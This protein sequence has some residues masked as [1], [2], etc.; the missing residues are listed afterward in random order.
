[1][2]FPN[3]GKQISDYVKET[4]LNSYQDDDFSR[5]MPGNKDF[6]SIGKNT[7]QQKRLLLCNLS[8]LYSAF[9]KRIPEIKMSFSKFCSLG[10]KWCILV[11]RSGT[12]PVR[13]CA[14]HHNVS[15]LLNGVNLEKEY[16][17]LV[18]LR[19]CDTNSKEC[20]IYRCPNCPDIS[21]LTTHLTNL[22]VD[23]EW[24]SDDNEIDADYEI[25][26]QQW[27]NVDWSQL[28]Q[29]SLP[30]KEFI[31]ILVEKLSEITT[32]SFIKKHNLDI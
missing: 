29:Q 25:Q 21:N 19:V 26:F 20:M 5:Q 8:E 3:L 11:G 32:H 22:L 30:V 10:P 31:E 27:I 15:L 17:K 4:V 13:V 9:K 24:S 16:H 2:L 28:V 1:M 6:I 18:S 14:I 23:I 12:H 7:L